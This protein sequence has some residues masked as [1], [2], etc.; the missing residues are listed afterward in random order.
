MGVM[1]AMD[2]RNCSRVLSGRFY[3]APKIADLPSILSK[4]LLLYDTKYGRFSDSKDFCQSKLPRPQLH[5][6]FR[7]QPVP[8]AGV[9]ESKSKAHE[10]THLEVDNIDI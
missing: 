9:A 1:L 3:T 4:K 6:A 5:I 10:L 8:G 7:L 2:L